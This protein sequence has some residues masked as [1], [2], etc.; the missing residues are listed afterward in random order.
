MLKV[1]YDFD[2][3]TLSTLISVDKN[4]TAE[5]K[6]VYIFILIISIVIII[7][8]RRQINKMFAGHFELFSELFHPFGV[9]C[10]IVDGSQYGGWKSILDKYIFRLS[11]WEYLNRYGSEW[12]KPGGFCCCFAYWKCRITKEKGWRKGS[13]A[14]MIGDLEDICKKQRRFK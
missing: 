14:E 10:A 6:Y 8:C 13:K 4:I 5:V 9:S 2:I 11:D 1:H 3:M 12:L 7:L